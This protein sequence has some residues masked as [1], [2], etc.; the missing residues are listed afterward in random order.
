MLYKH[1]SLSNKIKCFLAPEVLYTSE[2]CLDDDYNDYFR[3][4]R[5]PITY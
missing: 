5:I 2:K 4:I 1:E 3:D